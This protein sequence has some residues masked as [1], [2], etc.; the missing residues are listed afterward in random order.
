MNSTKHRRSIRLKDYDYSQIGAYFV[1][2]CA[3]NRE[4]LFGE[5]SQD[6]MILN[7]IGKLAH[8]NWLAIP[9]HFAHVDLDA[10]VVMPNHVH[11]IL[12]FEFENSHQKPSSQPI[13]KQSLLVGAKSGS[14]GAVIGSYK[15]S[16]TKQVNQIFNQ[17]SQ[18]VW[19]R[20]Y[21]EHI[22]RNERELLA[23]RK[24]IEDNPLKWQLDIEYF[25]TAAKPIY[26][27]HQNLCTNTSLMP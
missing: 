26:P 10:F 8:S 23:V 19:Q 6:M 16:V 24:Y 17:Q 4:C 13:T 3:N 5:I 1:T 12:L 18:Q 15:A 20:N 7:E 22:I 2:I 21:Y 25:N 9:E 11:G 27:D 14:L